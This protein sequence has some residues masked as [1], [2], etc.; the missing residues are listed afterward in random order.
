LRSAPFRSPSRL[1]LT[2][3]NSVCST[4]PNVLPTSP[5]FGHF[6]PGARPRPLTPACRAQRLVG[7]RSARPPAIERG[8][9]ESR[10]DIA[11]RRR[12]LDIPP[13]RES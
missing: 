4:M 1:A 7:A 10:A 9:H 13:L 5:W 6:R 12:A 2:Q 8:R 11:A 3:L